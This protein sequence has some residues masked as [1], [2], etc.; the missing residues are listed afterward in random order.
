[1]PQLSGEVTHRGGEHAAA[2]AAYLACPAHRRVDA[3]QPA[4]LGPSLSASP[5]VGDDATRADRGAGG[6]DDSTGG[7][8]CV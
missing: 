6:S 1:V 3:N 7:V 8:P 4:A 5:T 2:K